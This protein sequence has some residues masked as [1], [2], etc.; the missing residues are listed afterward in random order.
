MRRNNGTVLHGQM[1][2]FLG[3]KHAS[4][5]VDQ[6]LLPDDV[7]IEAV[8][9]NADVTALRLTSRRD[10][11]TQFDEQRRL[12]DHRP[13]P[14]TSTPT[15]SGPSTCSPPSRTAAGVR[16]GGRSRASCA[17]ATAARSSASAACWPGGWPRRACRWSTSATATRRKARGTRT[18][19]TSSR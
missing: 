16:P 7:R 19:R 15:I 2:G 11:L 10:L 9:P 8:E 1:P 12:I 5:D 17:S 6:E 4:F 18:A 3:A 13:R 14:A